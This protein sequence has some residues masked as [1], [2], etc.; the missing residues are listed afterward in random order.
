MNNMT[1]EEFFE[2]LN[3]PQ[4]ERDGSD[5]HLIHCFENNNAKSIFRLIGLDFSEMFK[6]KLDTSGIKIYNPK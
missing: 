5:W 2:I 6:Y 4:S 3:K 1:K